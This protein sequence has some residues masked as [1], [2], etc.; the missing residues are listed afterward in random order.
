[1]YYVIE[2]ANHGTNREHSHGTWE[3]ISLYRCEPSLFR[4]LMESYDSYSKPRDNETRETRFRRVS[5]SNA[6]HYHKVHG[7]FLCRHRH[8]RRA[9]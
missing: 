9:A 2:A 4:S 3:P 7:L 1:M 8:M 5:K 6:K